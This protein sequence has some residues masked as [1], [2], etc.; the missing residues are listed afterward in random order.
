MFIESIE[1]EDMVDVFNATAPNPVTN[2][3]FMAELRRA[4]HRPWCPP[5]PV[6]AVRLGSWLMQTD[7]VAGADRAAL[8]AQTFS[9]VRLQIPIPRIAWDVKGYLQMT[10]SLNDSY[11][12]LLGTMN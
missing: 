10:E 8:R 5:A 1:R 3:E 11:E 12:S 4:L 2:A 6:W 7:S 9:Q